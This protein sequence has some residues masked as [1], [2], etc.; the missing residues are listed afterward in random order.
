VL[1]L[2]IMKLQGVDEEE[3]EKVLRIW[4]LREFLFHG[5]E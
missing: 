1:Q 2:T 4:V 3:V 5:R